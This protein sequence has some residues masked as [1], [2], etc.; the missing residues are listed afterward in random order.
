MVLR[1]GVRGAVA[2]LA[3]GVAG[4]ASLA[5]SGPLSAGAG[6][7]ADRVVEAV[8]DGDT[9]RVRGV[10]T[11]RLI[12]IDTPETR[13]PER[14]E[15]CFGPEASAR[16]AELLPPGEPVRLTYDEDPRDRYD[17]TLAYVERAADGLFVN[18]DLVRTGHARAREY[19]PN[20]ARAVELGRLEREARSAGAGL[21]GACPRPPDPPAPAGPCDAAY[22]DV[23][24]P[25]PPPDLSCADAGATYFRAL[26]PD[27][28]GLD[29]NG[30]GVACELPGG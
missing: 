3:L 1:G 30:D 26:P 15:E 16:T 2:A 8:V 10:G 7:A 11:V 21:W 17:R 18:G 19:P 12:G 4:C 13:H 6:P 29:G 5:A 9:I 28:H 24:L 23:C 20:T 14:G 27:P 22:P 25:P